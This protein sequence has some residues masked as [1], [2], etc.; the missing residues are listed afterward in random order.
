MVNFQQ[1]Y[2]LTIEVAARDPRMLIAGGDQPS[3]RN[4]TEDNQLSW[5]KE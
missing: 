4:G 5:K 2:R 1:L 3:G